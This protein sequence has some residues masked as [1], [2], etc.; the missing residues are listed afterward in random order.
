MEGI[1]QIQ[2]EHIPERN[3][4]LVLLDKRPVLDEHRE[5]EIERIVDHTLD[6]I[7]QRAEVI[8]EDPPENSDLLLAI[9]TGDLTELNKLGHKES[10]R[11]L[12]EEEAARLD[13]LREKYP[14]MPKKEVLEAEKK[15][16]FLK[17]IA[18]RLQGEHG[19]HW[20]EKIKGILIKI[21]RNRFSRNDVP[22]TEDGIIMLIYELVYTE[23]LWRDK[24]RKDGTSSYF[25]A[26]LLAAVDMHIE[27][28][29]TGLVSLLSALKHDDLEDLPHHYRDGWVERQTE[30]GKEN[31]GQSPRRRGMISLIYINLPQILEIST[32]A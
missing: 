11:K 5:F 20:R 31:N 4:P 25:H 27:H 24:T 13:E 23:Y 1:P 15:T 26:H 9:Q 2:D 30:G 18:K 3:H 17:G 10:N 6:D 12:S 7:L 14:K 22:Y 19:E 29:L 16:V 8:R 21:E 32:E 28:G